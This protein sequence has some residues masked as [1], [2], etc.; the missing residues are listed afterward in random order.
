MYVEISINIPL[1]VLS[2]CNLFTPTLSKTTLLPCFQAGSHEKGNHYLCQ[3]FIKCHMCIWFSHALWN[4]YTTGVSFRVQTGNT[5]DKLNG[6]S[7][8]NLPIFWWVIGGS[9]GIVPAYQ[10]WSWVVGEKSIKCGQ[11]SCL[12]GKVLIL[13]LFQRSKS[14]CQNIFMKHGHYPFL[15]F[16]FWT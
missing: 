2:G 15:V 9:A 5:Y 4:S 14:T 13:L 8:T 7:I 6:V 16:T 3:Q 1:E 12:W 11:K 10:P